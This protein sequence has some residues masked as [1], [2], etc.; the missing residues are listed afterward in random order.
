MMDGK[1]FYRFAKP[2]NDSGIFIFPLHNNGKKHKIVVQKKGKEIV[3]DGFYEGA[4][5]WSKILEL[6]EQLCTENNIKPI[7]A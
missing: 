6:Y 2:C 4:A 1:R 3:E 5:L 7:P